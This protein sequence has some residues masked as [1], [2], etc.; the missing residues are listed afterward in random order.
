MAA[1]SIAT[2]S[3]S[4]GLVSIPVKLYSTKRRESQVSFH[5]LHEKCGNRVQMKWYCPTDDELVERKDLV[6]G[7]EV[8]KGKHVAIEE[9]ELAETREDKRDDIGIIEFVPRGA[10][11]PLYHEH[12]YYLAP[13]KAADKAYTILARALADSDRVAIGRY[14]ARGEEHVVAIQEQDGGL[15]MLQLRFADEVRPIDD[16]PVPSVR[17]GEQELGLAHKLIEQYAVDDF[18]PTRFKDAV[19]LRK[20]KLIEDKVEKGEVK[21]AAAAAREEATGQ[22]PAVIDLMAALKASLGAANTNRKAAANTNRKVTRPKRAKSTK[23]RR[24]A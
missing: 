4:F 19:K 6:R 1:R 8:E 17:V 12:D 2:A 5:W 11:N 14:A 24:A 18:D 23:R 3:L 16:V 15:V 13:D 20:L 9:E 7:F 22:K 21:K 10:I